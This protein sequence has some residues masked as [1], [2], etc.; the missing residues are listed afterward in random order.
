M[1]NVFSPQNII[2]SLLLAALAMSTTY[3]FLKKSR[4]IYRFRGII[5]LFSIAA[6]VYGIVAQDGAIIS[7]AAIFAGATQAAVKRERRGE[8]EPR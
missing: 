2:F 1:I 8:D 3:I 4:V 6:G 5:W 7:I